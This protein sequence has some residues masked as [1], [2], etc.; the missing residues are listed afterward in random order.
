[1]AQLKSESVVLGTLANYRNWL[2][3]LNY[4]A[5]TIRNNPKYVREF[6][7]WSRIVGLDEI[8]SPLL[9]RWFKHLS[10]RKNRVK[11]GGLSLNYIK[12]YRYALTHF[13]RFLQETGHIGFE[14]HVSLKS[15]EEKPCKVLSREEIAQLYAA[16][17]Y[18]TDP[19]I[20]DRG[21]LSARERVI[22]GLY[23][24][25]GLRKTEG[26]HVEVKDVD[27]IRNLLYVRKG[28]NAKER[29]VPIAEGVIKDLVHYLDHARPQLLRKGDLPELLVTWFGGSM[30]G[31]TICRKVHL[32]GELA[33]LD[34]PVSL[35]K[36]RHSI[37]TH[38]LQSGM[39][40]EQI[41]RFLGHSSLESTTIYTHIINEEI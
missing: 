6:I 22:L 25:C 14:V 8:T 37:A 38:L 12:S 13:S 10:V 17:D 2:E 3:T 11:E 21:L 1:M 27:L 34:D 36:L 20:K 23:Y 40:L 16:T 15:I 35:H 28:K 30:S 29:Y 18:Y 32:L 9:E 19:G 39:K 7:L 26:V 41:A 5:T 4:S 33:G 31:T 24:G